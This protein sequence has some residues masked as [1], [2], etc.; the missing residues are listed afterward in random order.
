MGTD[1]FSIFRQFLVHETKIIKL[2]D[3]SNRVFETAQ[4][5][6]C[7][8]LFP[9]KRLKTTQLYYV[10]MMDYNFQQ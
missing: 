4:V 7:I 10:T 3:L 9:K 5:K 8:I 2:T 1:S 6:T